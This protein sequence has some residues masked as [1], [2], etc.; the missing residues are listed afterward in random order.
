[1]APVYPACRRSRLSQL[2]VPVR[3]ASVLFVLCMV[4][5]WDHVVSVLTYD[6]QALLNIQCCMGVYCNFCPALHPRCRSS[7]SQ[8]VVECARRLPCCGPALRKRRRKRG[9]RGG[10]RVRIRRAI[11][12]SMEFPLDT[13]NLEGLHLMRRS[14]DYRYAFHLPVFPVFSHSSIFSPSSQVTLT[15][16]IRRRGVNCHNLRQLDFV[17]L[18]LPQSSQPPLNMA[19]VNARSICNKTFILNDF[20]TRHH[21]D[22]LFLTETWVSAGELSV[23]EELCPPDCCFISTPRSAGRG[24]GVAMV[25]KQSLKILTVSVRRYSSFEL[26]HYSHH[27]LLCSVLS[28][29]G[30]RTLT[31]LLLATSQIF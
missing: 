18:D 26:Q 1:M 16:R 31:M 27:P 5:H 15:L 20:L 13:M 8:P 12:S 22:M 6:R 19:L 30:H 28:S 29:I 21:L 2:V 9:S 25:F 17:H 14:W 24:G 10:V 7:Y 3:L 11:K 23:F 4:L